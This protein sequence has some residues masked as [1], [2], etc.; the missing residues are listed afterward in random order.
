MKKLLTSAV[1]FL[2]ICNTGKTQQFTPKKGSEGYYK[3]TTQ[4]KHRTGSEKNTATWYF[5]V[6]EVAKDSMVLNCTLLNY[7]GEAGGRLFNT[8]QPDKSR[9]N[10]TRDLEVLA[11]LN[12]PFLYHYKFEKMNE[13]P[14][15]RS[16]FNERIK[17]WQLDKNVAG[18]MKG[19]ERSYL[20][21]E[22]YWIVPSLPVTPDKLPDS[23]L[24]TDSLS[25]FTVLDRDAS[26]LQY[27]LAREEKEHKMKITGRLSLDLSTGMIRSATIEN[28]I[29]DDVH[30]ERSF[31]RVTAS[32]A[33]ASPLSEDAKAAIAKMS[34]F[35]E[36][37][38]N[39][40][41]YD[42][43][44]L[45][46]YF[47]QYDPLMGNITFYKIA[48]AGMLQGSNM[49]DKYSRYNEILTRI[50]DAAL[51]AYPHHLH[52]KL[53]EVKS[54]SV[55]SA[56]NTIRYLSR[57]KKSYGDWVQYTFA[58]E[59]LHQRPIE[60]L[61]RAWR[62]QGVPEKKIDKLTK[63]VINGRRIADPLM[64]KLAN[65][66]DTLIR[67]EVY[68]MYLWVQAMKHSSSKDSLLRIAHELENMNGS[69]RY[70]NHH[71]YALL[72]YRQLLASGHTKEAGML[73]SRQITAM[74]KNRLDSL[75]AD[76]F[77]EQNMLAYACKL[78]SDEL[79]ATDKKQAMAYLSKAA[80]YSPKNVKERAH[81]SFYDR[82]LLESKE[83]Y[84]ADFAEALIAQGNSKEAM[85]VLSEQLNADPSIFEDLKASF[86]KNFPQLDFYNFFH[87]YIIKSW[88]TAPDFTLKSPDAKTTYKLADYRGKWLLLDFWG[89]WCP[90]CREE[91]PKIN[92]F[93]QKIKGR[94]DLAF[95]SIAC[96]DQPETV[97]S[98]LA[99]HNYD[100]P[101]SMSDN[102]VQK[103]YEVP[104]Y[105]AKFLIS[106][107]G[108]VFNIPF[109]KDWEKA[110]EQFTGLQ[111]K[112]REAKV[113]THK[114]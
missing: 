76:R 81:S 113:Q 86:S 99:A 30:F 57:M 42:S 87:N 103:K 71:R 46:K 114:D 39:E 100:M 15:I 61:Q 6:L 26:S 53:Q 111:E 22:L 55:D 93:A 1:L 29:G 92:A 56:Y 8:A 19:N 91:M 34:D 54:I 31:N 108:T 96:R 28:H 83:S 97:I 88:K 7:D 63:D 69:K 4:L 106:P 51:A 95:L 80:M 21:N 85:K 94:N 109:G 24:S 90:P 60:E 23:W 72:V 5:K 10:N 41:G 43:L 18:N 79:A 58:Q 59:F 98:Y 38:K 11:L 32:E 35:S 40:D 68:P 78:K 89:T 65:D 16:I 17:D 27:G 52:N 62:K 102:Q 2:L 25:V 82:V 112:S 13:Q 107:S 14:G 110:V 73:L 66:E 48:K 77:T 84:R 44:K 45:E 49:N 70:S 3:I 75:D 9:T 105:P 37:L 50:E 101:A 36:A 74:E 47:A 20:V 33:G 64:E 12:R 67:N 104:G